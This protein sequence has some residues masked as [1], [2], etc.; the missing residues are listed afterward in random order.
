MNK[1]IVNSR[2]EGGFYLEYLHNNLQ[3]SRVPR[4]RKFNSVQECESYIN[5]TVISFAE[6]KNKE[7]NVVFNDLKVAFDKTQL[8]QSEFAWLDK[9]DERFCNWVW[10]YLKALSLPSIKELDSNVDFES[11]SLAH[12]WDDKN[13]FSDRYADIIKAFHCAEAEHAEQLELSVRITDKWKYIFEDKRMVNWLEE[14]NTN[15]QWDWVWAFLKKERQ[16]LELDVWTPMKESELQS[17]IIAAID[18]MDNIDSIELLLMKLKRAWSQKKFR[19]KSGGK[20]AYN[21]NMTIKTKQRLDKLAEHYD[22]KLNEV[23]E[24]LIKANYE[25]EIEGK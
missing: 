18:T 6:R 12:F 20:K 10:C 8:T 14:D 4:L 25:T 11:L 5:D 24:N 17:V 3:V 7:S 9:K 16:D 15:K 23:I 22:L 21:I 19:D 13:N 1:L 2:R